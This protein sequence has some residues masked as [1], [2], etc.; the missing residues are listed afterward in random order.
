MTAVEIRHSPWV[1][2]PGIAMPAGRLLAGIGDVHGMAPQ[3]DALLQSLRQDFA[4]AD[5]GACVWL[6]DYIDR[7][8]DA[9]EAVDI[10]RQPIAVT[11]V[12]T[13][14]LLGNHE[15]MLLDCIEPARRTTPGEAPAIWLSNGGGATLDSLGLP[16]RAARD[17]DLPARLIAALGPERLIFLRGLARSA[18]FGDLLF[19]HAGIDP[20]V[21]LADQD[22]DALIWIRE[23]FLMHRG[24]M[25]ENV[26]VIHGHSIEE[27]AIRQGGAPWRGGAGRPS[28]FGVDGGCFASGILTAVECRDGRARFVHAIGEPAY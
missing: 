2:L 14:C 21:P 22:P 24:A 4:A 11:G 10:A 1:D 12:E 17:H 16:R 8:P 27:P 7:G 19:V 20:A 13:I 6:G 25:P 5:G 28:R 3:A 18:R 23:P 26:L 15:A 9:V